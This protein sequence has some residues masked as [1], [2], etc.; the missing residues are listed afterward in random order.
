MRADTAPEAVRL[1]GHP[2]VNVY[3]CHDDVEM[4]E[5]AAVW[6]AELPRPARQDH[7]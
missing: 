4:P 1:V 7:P 5:G 2:E 6:F 3:P